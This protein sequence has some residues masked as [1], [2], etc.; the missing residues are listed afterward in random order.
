MDCCASPLGA[1]T[2]KSACRTAAQ[3]CPGSVGAFLAALPPLGTILLDPCHSSRA[4]C[5]TCLGCGPLGPP[6]WLACTR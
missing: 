5:Q 4:T 2:T 6:N 1:L 3:D